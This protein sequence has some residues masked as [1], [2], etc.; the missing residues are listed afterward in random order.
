[1]LEIDVYTDGSCLGNPG[2]AGIGAI[3]ICGKHRKEISENIGQSTNNRAELTAVLK[4]LSSIHHPWKTS[5]TI[6]TDSS[7]VIGATIM[8]WKLKKNMDL[9]TRIRNLIKRFHSIEVVKV[10]GHADNE[11]NIRADYL[12]LSAARRQ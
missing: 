6:Y 1:M 9:I 10:A 8:G 7:Y 5:V 2:P 4:A 3:L 12:A 11:L